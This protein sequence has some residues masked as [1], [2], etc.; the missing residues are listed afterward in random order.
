MSGTGILAYEDVAQGKY[1]C[2]STAVCDDVKDIEK[3]HEIPEDAPHGNV[4]RSILVSG[5]K[6]VSL[7]N[8][9]QTTVVILDTYLESVLETS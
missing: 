2:E 5:L 1:G 6:T 9:K 7:P 3:I 4:D 8:L